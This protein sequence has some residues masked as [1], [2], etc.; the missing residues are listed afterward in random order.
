MER[1]TLQMNEA[2]KELG[3]LL[4]TMH[5]L[6]GDDHG[7]KMDEARN[8]KRIHKAGK[9]WHGYNRRKNTSEH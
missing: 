3:K 1:T 8:K 2:M 9:V 6:I 5:N 7:I 4:K